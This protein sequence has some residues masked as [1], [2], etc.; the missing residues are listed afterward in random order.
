MKALF[1]AIA[2]LTV[3][4]MQSNAQQP[5]YTIEASPA[6]KKQLQPQLKQQDY[7]KNGESSYLLVDWQD[8]E[9][10]SEYCSRYCMRL[11]NENGV[12]NNSQLEFTFDPS[13]EKLAINKITIYRG[14]KT[15]DQL[16]PENIEVMRNEKNVDR[17]MYDG[18]YSAVVILK[19]VRVGDI[20]DY[21]YTIKGKNPIYGD[22]FYHFPQLAY[23]EEVQELYKSTRYPASQKVQYKL[24]AGAPEPTV[25]EANGQKQLVW[26][27]K[28]IK[29]IFTD[30]LIPQWYQAYPA[31]EISSFQTWGEVKAWERKLF[32]LKIQT[33]KIDAFIKEEGVGA[34][35]EDIMH[36][37][38]F[39]QKDVRYL[40]LEMGVF[41][42]KPHNPEDILEQRFGDC[43]DKSY[44]L[45]VMLRKIGV[46]AWPALVNTRIGKSLS[47]HLPSS[48]VFDHV[49]VKFRYKN[50]TYW[51]DATES[52][53][54]GGLDKLCFPGYNWALAI[55]DSDKGLESIPVQH[56]SRI[57]IE[58]HYWIPDSASE[59]TFEVVTNYYGDQANR[60]R[61]RQQNNSLY[62]S[63]D[64]YLD[65]YSS[66]FKKISWESDSALQF[67]DYADK[68]VFVSKERFKVNGLWET[69][70]KNNKELY[71]SF[72]P[73]N[74]YDYL[75]YTKD[76]DRTMPL[77]LQY[78]IKVEHSITLHFPSYKVF[79]LHEELDSIS[80]S[81]FR[82][83]RH[84]TVS[85]DGNLCVIDFTYETKTDAVPVSELKTYFEDYDKLSDLCSLS[86]Y[87]GVETKSPS[88]IAW[89]P[90]LSAILFAFG[91]GY[92]LT[93]AYRNDFGTQAGPKP[94]AI[95]G[96]L[97]L[98]IIGL[99]VT[100]F[101]VL[102]V[103]YRN[104]YFNLKTWYSVKA[105]NP[106]LNF[107]TGFTFYFELLFNT[108]LI[109]ICIFLLVQLYKRR[110]TFPM[111]YVIF[112]VYSLAGIIID[113]VLSYLINGNTP[114]Y[115]ALTREI[116]M[117][118]IW[119]PYFLYSEKVEECFTQVYQPEE[120]KSDSDERVVLD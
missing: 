21:E 40:G 14:D 34:D 107:L 30:E 32:D 31:A 113:D 19:D 43:K 101:Y 1:V 115:T 106:E 18:S 82:F 79:N 52:Q 42:H 4:C 58:E 87:W 6:W 62:E 39:V 104:N 45:S 28:N 77:A 103:L 13:Y 38:R 7:S 54:A 90:L 76:Q 88:T 108:G 109:L 56:L 67:T 117:A 75:S 66:R 10:S 17:L 63:R 102:N 114:D 5:S 84:Q 61:G 116:I 9:V 41:S 98:P 35:P 12:Q 60:Q 93:T 70:E 11:N 110:T 68:N 23:S 65:F 81:C 85:E 2:L 96:W 94:E 74:M 25:T 36:L 3:L 105:L 95:G 91:F 8:N 33:P 119:I 78:P 51:V 37:I 86:L 50:E 80:N 26:D 47:D 64:N 72:N 112:R 46:E 120:E 49:I 89:G 111:A 53:Q 22:H 48:L 57:K 27:L 69:R 24:L 20:L 83:V 55:D 100:P 92:Y 73:Y 71:A 59:A 44:L 97:I 99:H 118:A 15:I 29:P 16:K